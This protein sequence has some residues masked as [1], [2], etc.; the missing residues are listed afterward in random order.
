[1]LGGTGGINAMLYVKGNPQDYEKWSELSNYNW[2]YEHLL[3]HFERSVMPVQNEGYVMLANHT[4]GCLNGHG[5]RKAERNPL[6]KLFPDMI[7]EAAEE[8]ELPQL[9]DFDDGNYIGFAFLKSTA[10]FG[11]RASTGKSYLARVA[12]R[13][14]LKVIKNA[15]VTSLNFDADGNR[16]Y[17]VNFI[18]RGEKKFTAAARNEFILSAG[19][20]DTPKIL[21]LS[22]VGPR[23]ELQRVSLP[24]INDLPI[25][26]NLQ[27]HV[28]VPVIFKMSGHNVEPFTKQQ[29]LNQIY[30]YLSGNCGYLSSSGTAT[31]T[32][33]INTKRNG[34]YPDIQLHHLAVQSRDYSG[35][36]IFLKGLTM[37]Q[38]YI[39]FLKHLLYDH[40]LLFV[41]VILLNPESIGSLKPSSGRYRDPPIID[42][43]YLDHPDDLN[44]LLNGIRFVEEMEKTETFQRQQMELFQMP[45]NECGSHLFRSIGYWKCYMKYFSTTLYHPVGTVKMAPD[46]EKLGGCVNPKLKLYGVENLRV[47]D[48]SIMPTITSGNTNAPTIMIAEHANRLI[49]DDWLR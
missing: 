45:L 5:A 25:G 32:G 1:M 29:E 46:D 20:I 47:V 36:E 9:N 44:T 24:T 19:A 18:L 40:H 33:F 17:S 38:N 6:M 41:Y 21:W 28:L 16:V 37:K 2:N 39:D 13:P 27:D 4:T 30:E 22:G 26:A 48:A 12:D 15:Q 49:R 11:R 14:N 8:L 7:L 31:L 34:I 43:N 42:A 3:P 35:L 10:Q 23:E